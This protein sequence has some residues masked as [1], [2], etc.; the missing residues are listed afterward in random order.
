MAEPLHTTVRAGSEKRRVWAI[1]DA[2]LAERGAPPSG[3]E[4][5]DRYVAEGGNE[6]TGFTQYSHWKKA[7]SQREPAGLRE[8]SAPFAAAAAGPLLLPVDGNGVLRL[9]PDLTAALD[10]AGGGVV[11]ARLE[12]GAVR[13]TSPA[14]AIRRIQQRMAKYKKPGASVVDGF[15][16]ERRALWGEA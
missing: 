16:A 13:L 1:C 5:V 4:V 9:P 8:G 14:A 3:R 6:G 12:E 2:L 11:A 7:L 15:L 10:V